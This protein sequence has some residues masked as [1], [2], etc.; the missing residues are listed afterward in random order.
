MSIYVNIFVNI[1]LFTFI[2]IVHILSLPVLLLY[3]IIYVEFTYINFTYTSHQQSDLLC[4]PTI[5]QSD[6]SF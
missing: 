4:Y 2:I 1:A 3:C 6:H 5:S